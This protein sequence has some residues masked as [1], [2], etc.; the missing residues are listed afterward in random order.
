MST[1]DPIDDLLSGL[2][3]LEPPSSLQPRPDEAFRNYSA[4]SKQ[5]TA[6]LWR[7][8]GRWIEPA[9]VGGFV[10]VFVVWALL[11]VLG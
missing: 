3:Q 7:A 10:V 9:L 1:P 4:A 2:K 5:P 11:R 8:W 6:G